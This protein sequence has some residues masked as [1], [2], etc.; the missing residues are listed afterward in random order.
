MS[1]TDDESRDLPFRAVVQRD[2]DEAA[3][4]ADDMP[5]DDVGFGEDLSGDD[6]EAA[7]LRALESADLVLDETA[8]GTEAEEAGAPEIDALVPSAT[9]P[10][11]AAEAPPETTEP[12][13]PAPEAATGPGVSSR[14]VVEALL[15][16]GGAALTTRKLTEVLGEGF[17]A[18]QIEAIVEGLNEEYASENRPYSIHWGEGGYRY[19]LRPEFEKVRNRVFGVGPKEV[20]LSQEALEVLALVAYR[21]PLRSSDLEGTE[22]KNAGSLVRQLIRRELVELRRS[23]AAP[24]DPTYHTT[25][26]FLEL[27]GLTSLD[28]LPFPAD[29]AF[30]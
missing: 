26:R 5:E 3:A 2:T 13:S 21:Q 29:F 9:A 18:E 11:E 15:F 4:P 6:I 23:D 16:V 27:F 30:K 10:L 17:S 12:E 22:R 8:P 28:D 25:P 1:S 7:Y 14:Q 24:D 19:Q 20:K